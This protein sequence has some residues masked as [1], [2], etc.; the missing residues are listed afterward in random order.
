MKNLHK[1]LTELNEKEIQNLGG[2]FGY[3]PGYHRDTEYSRDLVSSFLRGV[4]DAISK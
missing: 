2:G 4:Y 3:Y 1:N